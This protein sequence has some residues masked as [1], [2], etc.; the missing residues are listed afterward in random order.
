[1]LA[2]LELGLQQDKKGLCIGL[3]RRHASVLDLTNQAAC[4]VCKR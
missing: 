1:M 2:E 4:Q 3:G